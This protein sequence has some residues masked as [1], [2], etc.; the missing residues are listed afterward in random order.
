MCRI[1]RYSS[2]RSLI[3]FARPLRVSQP[4]G[5]VYQFYERLNVQ[6]EFRIRI[7][8]AVTFADWL[9]DNDAVFIAQIIN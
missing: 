4:Y 6:F 5:P 3:V 7:R 9:L 1:S 8:H 2:T